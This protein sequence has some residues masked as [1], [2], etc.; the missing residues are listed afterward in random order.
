MIERQGRSNAGTDGKGVYY[1]EKEKTGHTFMFWKKEQKCL[2]NK[3]DIRKKAE[4][5]R[6]RD[7]DRV[8]ET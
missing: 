6:E 1:I 3:K 8:M 2:N 7:K 5:V 4:G